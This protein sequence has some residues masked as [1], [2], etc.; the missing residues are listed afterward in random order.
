M[1]EPLSTRRGRKPRFTRDQVLRT[2]LELVDAH[3]APALSMRRIAAELG[4]EAMSLYGYVANRDEL[5]DGLSEI[6]VGEMFSD[7]AADAEWRDAVEAFARATR[8][9]AT[10]HP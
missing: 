6:L 7:V 5:L 3:G 1:T 10:S 2:A 4:I 8:R 9:T